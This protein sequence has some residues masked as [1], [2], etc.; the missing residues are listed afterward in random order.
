MHRYFVVN[1]GRIIISRHNL[2]MK[3]CSVTVQDAHSSTYILNRY[4]V[5]CK[6]FFLKGLLY[7]VLAPKK[8]LTNFV[9]C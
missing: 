2:A 4:S 6:H 5:D 1:R 7:S 3:I 8:L 9:F